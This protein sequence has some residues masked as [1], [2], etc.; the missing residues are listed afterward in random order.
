MHSHL[1]VLFKAAPLMKQKVTESLCVCTDG[2]THLKMKHR[3][4]QAPLEPQRRTNVHAMRSQG[5]AALGLVQR[6][7]PVIIHVLQSCT[8][9]PAV[10]RN[11]SF[12]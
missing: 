7:T 5:L 10:T 11:P 9:D 2:K 4:H 8:V 12:Y 3:H 1:S 6:Q